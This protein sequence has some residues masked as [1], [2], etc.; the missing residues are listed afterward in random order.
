MRMNTGSFAASLGTCVQPQS[1]EQLFMP[2]SD[3]EKWLSWKKYFS[4]FLVSLYEAGES[5][6]YNDQQFQ[7]LKR[8]ESLSNEN[9]SICAMASEYVLTES[10]LP[11]G[12]GHE[13]AHYKQLI[14]KLSTFGI[15]VEHL[16]ASSVLF[17]C[18]DLL[19]YHF[20]V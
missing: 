9:K 12:A 1:T 19:H 13:H 18:S 16:I 3:V 5:L 8:N 11:R 14:F 15:F 10:I 6:L 7:S 20:F 4:S 17:F 2:V